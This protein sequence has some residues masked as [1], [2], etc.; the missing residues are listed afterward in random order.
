M[1]VINGLRD[2]CKLSASGVENP[3]FVFETRT[4]TVLGKDTDIQVVRISDTTRNYDTTWILDDQINNCMRCATSFGFFTRR[5][6][7]RVCGFLFCDSCSNRTVGIPS[8]R[9]AS[10]SCEDCFLVTKSESSI[11]KNIEEKIENA[12]MTIAVEGGPHTSAVSDPIKTGDDQNVS[13][14][15]ITDQKE[16]GVD[17]IQ[18]HVSSIAVIDQEEIGVG[19][20]PIKSKG[21]TGAH[22]HTRHFHDHI[23]LPRSSDEVT[24]MQNDDPSAVNSVDDSTLREDVKELTSDDTVVNTSVSDLAA[25][26]VP[27]PGSKKEKVLLEIAEIQEEEEN[28]DEWHVHS[29]RAQERHAQH[30]A[31]LSHS[32][33]PSVSHDSHEHGHEHNSTRSIPLSPPSLV[34]DISIVDTESVPVGTESLV[35]EVAGNED[36]GDGVAEPEADLGLSTKKT[37]KKKRNNR[38]K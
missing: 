22:H 9:L 24:Y 14:I 23:Q 7:C 4:V 33:S 29:L 36:S 21:G 10:R 16:N 3:G 38:K 34:E 26:I 1:D 12:D 13:F 18:E 25:N 2:A 32:H 11:Q 31:Q 35:E 37:N 30:R 5:H 15:A 19:T 6:H 20:A 17:S 8:L 27:S 28:E